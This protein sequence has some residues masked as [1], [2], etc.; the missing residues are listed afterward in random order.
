[1]KNSN[2]VNVQVKIHK[3]GHLIRSTFALFGEKNNQLFIFSPHSINEAFK[4]QFFKCNLQY[5]ENWTF[6]VSNQ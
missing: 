5:S 4:I 3:Q 1:M 6:I 2:V